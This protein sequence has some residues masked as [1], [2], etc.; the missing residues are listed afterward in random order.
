MRT[1][2]IKKMGN[3]FL[4]MLFPPR[5]SICST[6]IYRE[7]NGCCDV[8]RRIFSLTD[9]QNTVNLGDITVYSCFSYADKLRL[10]LDNFKF[11]GKIEYA[12]FYASEMVAL[13][14]KKNI[15]AEQLTSVVY[16]PMP[17]E[18]ELGRGYNQSKV[19]AERIAESLGLPCSDGGLARQNILMQ[20]DLNKSMR[21]KQRSSGFALEKMGIIKGN[22][23]LVDDI[24]TTGNTLKSCAG[25]LQEGGAK[26]IIAITAAKLI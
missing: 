20:H 2:D 4:D 15:T 24:C 26:N 13:L 10:S 11:H 23:L 5:C 12:D 17:L 19:L 25:L 8:C 16:I 18:R 6:V 21:Q 7:S 14:C 9:A 1:A 22:V 3:Q